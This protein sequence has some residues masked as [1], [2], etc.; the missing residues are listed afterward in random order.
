MQN[1][2]RTRTIRR[3]NHDVSVGR[4]LLPLLVMLLATPA[5]AQPAR[6]Q[7]PPDISGE[8]RLENHEEDTT[9]QPPL[10]NYLG[11]PFNDAGRLRADTTA[12]SIWG[13]PEYQCRPHSA[14][15]QWRGLGGARI[16]KEQDPLTRDVRAY[17]VQFMRSL[18]RPIYMDGR[19]HPPAFAP[20]SWTGFSTGEWVGKTLKVTTTHLKDGYLKRGG[21]QT[22][23]LFTMTEF[24]TRHDDILTIVSVVDDPIYM[25]EP[26]VQS[27]TYVID[28]TASVALETCNASSF[29][30]NGGTDRHWVPH[31]LPG[32]NTALTE[33]LQQAR[34]IPADAARGGV[35]TLYPEYRLTLGGSARAES[36]SVPVSRSA[37]SVE[38]GIADQ[39]P[40][41][42]QVHILPV[43]GNIYMLVA[44]GNN[45]TASIGPEGILLVNTGTTEMSDAVLAALNELAGAV[46]ARPVPNTCFGTQ[47][48]GT[49]GWA[50][51]YMS[52]VI[53]SPAPPKPVR[54]IVNTSGAADHVGG[55]ETIARSGFFPRGGG[56]GGA[57]DNVGQ[58]ASIIAHENVL[59]RMSARGGPEASTPA[60]AWPTDT[61]FDEFHKLPNYFNG[62]AVIVY[63]APAANT[64]GDSFVFFRRSEV[65]SAGHLFS[66]VSYPVIDVDRGGTIQGVIDGLNQIL[67]LAVAEYRAQGGTWIVPGR[68]RLSDTADV[69]SYRNMLTVIRDRVRDLIDRGMTLDQVHAARPTM[70]FDAR[71][72]ATGGAWTT[73]MFVEAVYRSLVAPAAR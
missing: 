32:Q 64:D 33:W 58:I 68:G 18:D 16:L 43:Q 8:W 3:S 66:T 34:W 45:I 49:W 4:P 28:P 38:R 39:S 60:A 29:A 40:R 31:F 5:F 41:D 55:N 2:S 17:H 24:I 67:D 71:Y 46:V 25:D 51:P 27:T 59:T 1:A 6:P 26:Y 30:E 15:H 54:Y 20:H 53:G 37:V 7:T 36:L 22:S 19:P 72:G 62:E 11:I 65:I 69:A 57:V 42:G 23:D 12:E 61:Y 48:P 70:D 13:T 52:S 56:F 21:P 44:D 63:H 14:P 9:L 47:C 10:G 35:K 50:S 73:D